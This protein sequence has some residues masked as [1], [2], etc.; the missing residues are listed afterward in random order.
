M[1]FHTPARTGKIKAF[2]RRV[3]WPVVAAFAGLLLVSALIW[4]L[5]AQNRFQETD[6]EQKD[7]LISELVERGDQIND[8][9]AEVGRLT[10]RLGIINDRA[11]R[12]RREARIERET[13]LRQQRQMLRI[14]RSL[15]VEVAPN[16]GVIVVTPGGN[17]PAGGGGGERPRQPRE[18]R[19]PGLVPPLAPEP[20]RSLLEDLLD[21]PRR[22]L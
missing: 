21:A 17:Q 16:A 4:N 18:P 5:W 14:L 3:D 19:S 13:L 12:E 8:L 6:L 1:T 15:G 20:P 2:W 11:D 10:F 9:Q 7:I 22:L